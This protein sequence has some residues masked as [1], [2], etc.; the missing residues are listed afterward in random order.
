VRPFD[1]D[2]DR[3]DGRQR[4]KPPPRRWQPAAA[5]AGP[6]ALPE[7][8]PLRALACPAEPADVAAAVRGIVLGEEPP[9]ARSSGPRNLYAD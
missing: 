2:R 7:V 5:G 1:T 6:R 3:R 9:G 8:R 4:R